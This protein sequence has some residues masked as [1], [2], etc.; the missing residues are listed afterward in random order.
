MANTI[1]G[2]RFFGDRELLYFETTKGTYQVTVYVVDDD[3]TDSAGVGLYIENPNIVR[4]WGEAWGTSEPTTRGITLKPMSYGRTRIKFY[5]ITDPSKYKYL[6]VQVGPVS[7]V[8][9][10]QLSRSSVYLVKGSQGEQVRAYVDAESGSTGISLAYSANNIASVTMSGTS[11]PAV[12]LLTVNPINVG[13]TVVTV[14]SSVDTTR[15]AKLTVKVVAAEEDIPSGGGDEGGSEGG[16]GGGGSTPSGGDWIPRDEND[17]TPLRTSATF[18]DEL[19]ADEEISDITSVGNTLIISTPKNMY[20]YLWR[21]GAYHFLGNKIPVPAIRFR[22]GDLEVDRTE[23]YLVV[24][25][26]STRDISDQYEFFG[27]PNENRPTFEHN[28]QGD[29][30]EYGALSTKYVFDPATYDGNFNEYINSLWSMVDRQLLEQNTQGKAVFPIFVR[31]AVRLYDGTSYAQSIPV[32]LGADVAKFM[33]I[34]ANGYQVYYQRSDN[35]MD[36]AA[37]TAFESFADFV[38]GYSIYMDTVGQQV[39]FDGWDDIVKEIDI[40]VSRQL[41]PIQRDAAKIVVEDTG[42]STYK[43]GMIPA[44]V[45]KVDVELDPYYSSLHQEELVGFCQNT[46][47]AQSFSIDEFRSLAGEKKLDIN[48]S[49]DYIL[50]QE[51]LKETPQSMHYTVGANLFNYNNRL[52]VTGAEQ[53]L[54]HGYPFLHSVKWKSDIV[55]LPSYRF[56]YYLRGE[57]G[58]NIVI[59]RDENGNGLITPKQASVVNM[60]S[61]VYKESPVAWFA[62]PDSRCYRIDVYRTIGSTVEFA[63]FTTKVFD[64]ADVAYV[65]LGFGQEYQPNMFSDTLPNTE[66]DT[67]RMPS[68]LVVSKVNNPFVFPAEDVVTF[69]AGEVLNIAVASVPLSEGQ[70]GQFPLYVFTDEGVFAMT[71]DAEGRLRT[72][73]NVGRDILLS[74]GALVGIE[75]GVFFAAARG[76]LLLQGSR[77][78]K[79]SSE[80]DGM[81]DAVE[82]SILQ[83][84]QGLLGFSVEEPQALR[85]FLADCILAYD[86]A[87]TRIIVANPK[88]EAMYAYKFDTQS[89]HRLQTSFGKPVRVLNAFPEAQLAMKSGNLQSLLDFSVLAENNDAEP[90]RGL[91]YTRDLALDSADIYKTVSRLK[92]RGRFRDGHVK[93]QL[94]GSNDGL[95][96]ATVHSLRGPS[97]KWYR[98]VLVTM[99]EKEERVSYIELD[100]EPKFTDK[101][102]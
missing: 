94:Q 75:Q 92:V 102:R 50:A 8:N 93:W 14:R 33:D 6:T 49:S 19:G 21:E 87:N 76:L 28:A 17:N 10:V 16:S 86:Y 74:K 98:I 44:R 11:D 71:V 41:F 99:L 3:G 63:S 67:Y 95:T 60:S 4:Y 15:Y 29:I 18:F 96:Y 9:G 84:V 46:Y 61:A 82:G 53:R 43:F 79:V 91:V 64:Q 26:N 72:S 36:M 5:S 22:I 32:L 56:V 62:Y 39:A 20:Y 97:W 55:T 34:K 100:Y 80:M 68:T 12:T 65:F 59:C 77:V 57:N 40:F 27:M 66:S 48:F 25:E 85:S 81:P 58:E 54:S 90:L 13:E 31:Y 38:S 52:L 2:I 70:A 89:W 42:N 45:F 101:M 78:T 7:A 1:H 69:T 88:Y 30:T 35:G 37:A 24:D 23:P 73:H 83:P 51:P 47:L